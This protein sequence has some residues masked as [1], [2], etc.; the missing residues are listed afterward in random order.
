MTLNGPRG[1]EGQ[2]GQEGQ[3]GQEGQSPFLEGREKG[4]AGR[5]SD[6][7]PSLVV[8]ALPARGLAREPDSF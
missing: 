7:T 2:E 6:R 1:Q 5:P 3:K 8:K 4:A